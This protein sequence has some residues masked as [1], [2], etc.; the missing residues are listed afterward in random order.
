LGASGSKNFNQSYGVYEPHL[1]SPWGSPPSSS[2]MVW[3]LSY[4]WKLA[5]LLLG[6]RIW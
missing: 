1:P 6:A 4:P 3:M 2:S 5:M